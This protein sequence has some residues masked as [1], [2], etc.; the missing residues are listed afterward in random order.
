MILRLTLFCFSLISFVASGSGWIQRADFGGEARHRTTAVALGNSVY[1]GLGHYNGAGPNILFD[2]WWEYDPATNAWTQKAN[3]MGGETYHAASFSINNIAY[4]GT[5][6]V[7]STNLVKDFYKY[8]PVSN[9]WTQ[10]SDFP[11]SG[12]RGGV[13]FAIDGFGY[14]GT[15]T[16]TSDF[17]KYNPT[18]DSWVSVASLPASGRISAV[19][20]EMGGYGYVG[21]GTTSSSAENDFWRYDPNTDSWLEMAEVG[22]SQREEASGFSLNGK[23]YIL[24]GADNTIGQD[25]RDMW[26]YNPILDSWLQIEDFPGTSRRYL[27]SIVLNNQAFCGLGTNGVNFK[28]FWL[29]DPVLNVL[30]NKLESITVSTFPNPATEFITIQ[31]INLENVPNENF[32]LSIF[33]ENGKRVHS[34]KIKQKK[35]KIKTLGFSKGMYVCKISY[36]NKPLKCTKFVVK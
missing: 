11:G 14:V 26:E 6:R 13:G 23:G 36:L 27:S 30:E 18:N 5:G 16:G 34:Q 29:F 10:I 31:I 33:S 7:P 17:F 4:V 19:G 9:S 1:F 21:T 15:G 32:R 24:T 22:P 35:I 20:F 3:Y 28:D 25:F 2:D 12:R 8:N